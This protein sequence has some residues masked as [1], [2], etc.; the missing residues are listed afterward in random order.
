MLRM[1]SGTVRFKLQLFSQLSD[2]CDTFAR[3]GLK[4]MTE[5]CWPGINSWNGNS[6]HQWVCPILNSSKAS[7]DKVN[8]MQCNAIQP[9]TPDNS[10]IFQSTYCILS[11]RQPTIVQMRF[12]E[13]VSICV[14]GGGGGKN[15]NSMQWQ[16]NERTCE[17]FIDRSLNGTFIDVILWIIELFSDTPPNPPLL[18]PTPQ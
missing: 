14:D 13:R 17:P 12:T 2:C 7:V 8:A 16:G 6:D 10:L 1:M 9:S 18:Y 4:L 5:Y 11:G 3:D 15:N